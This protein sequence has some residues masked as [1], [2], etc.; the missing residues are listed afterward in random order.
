VQRFGTVGSVSSSDEAGNRPSVKI[1]WAASYGGRHRGSFIPA[2]ESVARRATGRGDSLDVVVPDVGPAA[3]HDQVR[4]LGAGLTIVPDGRAA[5]AATRALRPDVVHAHFDNWLVGVTLAL[6]TS[7]ARIL[8]HVHSTR[9]PDGGPLRRTPKRWV[10]FGLIGRRVAAF[11]CVTETI[12]G[13]VAELGADPRRVVVVRNAVDTT[14]FVPPDAETRAR[15]R[16]R[17]GLDA[18]PAIAFFGRDPAIKGADYLAAALP[19]VPN[20]V[21]V[22]VATPE[23]ARTELARSAPVVDVP[24]LE[25]VREVLWAVDAVAIPS[26]GEGMPYVALEAL[27]CGVPVVASDLGWAHELAAERSGVTLAR[28]G[29]A[30]ALAAALRNVTAAHARPAPQPADGIERWTDQIMA[31]YDGTALP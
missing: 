16:A 23:E 27:A 17:L 11:V 13:E 10:K 8:W 24:F 28:R 19:A 20:V 15:M 26:R 12:A 6:W 29:D 25:D 9:Q 22:A 14:R 3:W 7:R 30:G 2:L 21:V 18:R 31:L 1:V 4:A 5:A